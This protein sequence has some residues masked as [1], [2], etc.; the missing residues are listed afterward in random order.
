[1]NYVL[2]VITIL[3]IGLFVIVC[4]GFIFALIGTAFHPHSI[5][6]LK[7][8]EEDY[9]DEPDGTAYVQL[10]SGEVRLDG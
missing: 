9:W 8:K 5:N 6:N 7:Y 10:P 1:M 3:C 4:F 2:L